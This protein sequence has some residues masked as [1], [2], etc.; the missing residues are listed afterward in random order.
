ML[1]SGQ[2]LVSAFKSST[3]QIV[4]WFRGTKSS[5]IIWDFENHWF[6]SGENVHLDFSQLFIS[7]ENIHKAKQQK[8]NHHQNTSNCPFPQTDPTSQFV[9]RGFAEGDVDLS[10]TQSWR[11]RLEIWSRHC[12]LGLGDSIKILKI[13]LGPAGC[14]RGAVFVYV[15]SKQPVKAPLVPGRLESSKGDYLP[16]GV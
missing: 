1:G 5:K 8:Q 12:V 9:F 2:Q 11:W 14:F 3:K 16:P 6:N 7:F 4:S 15:F 10:P 13:G